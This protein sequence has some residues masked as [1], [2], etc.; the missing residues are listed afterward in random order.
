[1]ENYLVIRGREITPEVLSQIISVIHSNWDKGRTQI[2]RELCRIWNWQYENG[3]LKDQV[4]RILLRK[5]EKLELITLPPPLNKGSWKNN[6]RRHL[7]IPDQTPE[8]KQTPIEGSLKEFGPIRLEMVRRTPLEHLWN[9]LVH[10]YHYQGLKV[11]VGAHL[12]YMAFIEDQPIACLA[13]SSS[14]FRIRCRD[15]YIGWNYKV[16]NSNIR[17][18]ANNS[19]FLILPWIRIRN[20][21]THVLSRSAKVLP[22]D[23]KRIYG[24]PVYVAETFVDRSR[25]KG[26]CYRAANWIRVGQ[27]KGHAKTQGQFYY[28]GNCKDIYLYPLSKDFKERLNRGGEI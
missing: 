17:Y 21:A 18:I 10:N 2:S 22:F 7:S 12:K 13:F 15:E 14:V 20:L 1:M 28:H 11:L 26:T 16:R 19:R 3:A 24:H 27:S 9:F 23:W 25:F 4:C 6:Q 8:F 5:L